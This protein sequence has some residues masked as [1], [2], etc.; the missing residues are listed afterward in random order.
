MDGEA[1]TDEVGGLVGMG[2]L[3]RTW[4]RERKLRKK[5]CILHFKMKES[6]QGP[7]VIKL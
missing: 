1:D 2:R 4:K 7:G 6:G 5:G 3:K